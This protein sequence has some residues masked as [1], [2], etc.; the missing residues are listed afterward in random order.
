MRIDDDVLPQPDFIEKLIQ[1]INAGYDIAS[2]LIPPL[3]MPE[4]KREI[5][6]LNREINKVRINEQGDLI[7]FG[8]D[9]GMCYIEK[10]IIPAGHFR[11]CALYKSEI[12]SKVKYQDNLSNYGFREESFF[13]LKCR[14]LGYKIG[15]HTGAISYHI[16]TPS[17]GGRTT[18]NPESISIDDE[19]F[20][21][22][23]KN[24]YL[25]GEL[26]L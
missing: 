13:S 25:S 11:S 23:I 7:E 15:V 6:F 16:M 4:M 14:M 19:S 5:R 26:K 9:C 3:A 12:N 21:K 24:K 22:W 20:R 8:D 17:G 18:A 2:G 1:V 10:E